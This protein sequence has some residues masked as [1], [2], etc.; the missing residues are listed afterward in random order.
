MLK[1]TFNDTAVSKSRVYEYRRFQDGP[2][3]VKDDQCPGRTT[4]SVREVVHDVDISIGSRHAFF[5]DVAKM[6]CVQE[7]F[8]FETKIALGGNCSGF[9]E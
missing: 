7:I 8:E 9:V 6:R 2:E 1:V 4:T 5:L 3:D